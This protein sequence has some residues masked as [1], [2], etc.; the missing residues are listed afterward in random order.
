MQQLTRLIDI[1]ATELSDAFARR[2][3]AVRHALADHPLFT[4]DA[5]ADL[6]DGLP[7]D[8]VRRERGDLPLANSG[9]GYVEVG[10][11]RPPRAS[12]TSNSSATGSRCATST[13]YRNTRRS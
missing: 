3:I 9:F 6:A 5:I 4:I 8:S 2:S 11:E 7:P 13:R 1:D 12:E 10:T